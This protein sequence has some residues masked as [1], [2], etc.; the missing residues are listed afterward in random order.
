[1]L[2]YSLYICIV[3]NRRENRANALMLFNENK[4]QYNLSKV[5]YFNEMLNLKNF[6]FTLC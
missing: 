3:R 6:K 4:Y 2:K 5:N 1:M